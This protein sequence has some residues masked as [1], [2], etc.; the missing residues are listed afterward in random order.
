MEETMCDYSLETYRS[1]PAQVGERYE[2]HRF[3]TSSIGFIAPGDPST[4]VCM[5]C[6][7]KLGLEDIPEKVQRAYFV[8]PKEEVV[9]SRLE[10]G[11]H[12]DGVRF[13]N[14]AEVTLQD[15]GPGVKG[16]LY[17]TL[18]SSSWYPETVETV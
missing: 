12:H 6:D 7:T 1:R 10:K 8:S 5:A 3:P 15:L 17:D 16:Y 11:P 9:F 13:A 18:V 4:A 2:T 14:G